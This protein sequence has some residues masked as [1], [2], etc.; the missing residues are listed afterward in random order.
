MLNR[1]YIN[2]HEG[3]PHYISD[4]NIKRLKSK[5]HNSGKREDVLL[6]LKT[7][8]DPTR[9]NIYL[10]LHKIDEIPVTDICHVL[11][12]NQSTA[13]HALSDLKKLSLVESSRCGQLVCYSL[14]KQPR[15]RNVWLSFFD[16][17]FI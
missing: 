16:K 14:K 13:S 4:K 8:S 1:S 11:D 3:H 15:K 5:F 7:L 12:L 2:D 17:F 9:L 10:L 6:I